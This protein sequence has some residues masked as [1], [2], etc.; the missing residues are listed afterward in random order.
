M[1]ASNGKDVKKFGELTVDYKG[2]KS[3]AD[4]GRVELG[5]LE[6]VLGRILVRAGSSRA[7]GSGSGA[8]GSRA[9][10]SRMGS[11]GMGTGSGKASG[12]RGS[13]ALLK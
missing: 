4:A 3:M 13:S 5:F 9:A 12:S 11:S 7:S 2:V 10:G 6:T 8:G 1:R